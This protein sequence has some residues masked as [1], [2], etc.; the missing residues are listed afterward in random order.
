MLT[1]RRGDGSSRSS[2]IF[3]GN[4]VYNTRTHHRMCN[5]QYNT[6][7]FIP[8]SLLRVQDAA[9]ATTPVV[10]WLA[11]MSATYGDFDSSSED[12]Q[13]ERRPTTEFVLSRSSNS[14]GKSSTSNGC[15]SGSLGMG[16]GDD[17]YRSAFR[18]LPCLRRLEKRSGGRLRSTSSSKSSGRDSHGRKSWSVDS[19]LPSADFRHDS[20]SSSA[21][22][23]TALS[24]DVRRDSPPSSSKKRRIC[25]AGKLVAPGLTAAVVPTSGPPPVACLSTEVLQTARDL[26]DPGTPTVR[27]GSMPRWDGGEVDGSAKTPL[28]GAS[29]AVVTVAALSLLPPVAEAAGEGAEPEGIEDL[30]V[31]S[32]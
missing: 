2:L 4:T 31:S 18:D 15:N 9:M 16:Q 11:E 7:T 14:V 1:I 29:A 12:E 25:G 10:H 3:Y 13:A 28:G 17:F 26:S 8:N 27:W 30:L 6:V 23:S 22:M 5:R 24:C 20:A 19:A 32:K 21:C